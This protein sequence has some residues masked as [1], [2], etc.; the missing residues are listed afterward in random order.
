MWDDFN[1]LKWTDFLAES[2]LFAFN[3]L[4][5]VYSVERNTDNWLH[6]SFV[7]KDAS[8][9]TLPYRT[10]SFLV[11][12][13]LQQILFLFYQP[14]VELE[15]WKRFHVFKKV[16]NISRFDW[17]RQ[18]RMRDYHLSL[19]ALGKVK[20]NGPRA[21]QICIGVIIGRS[22]KTQSL[23]D[24]LIGRELNEITP[25]ANGRLDILWQTLGHGLA[26]IFWSLV[27]E[28]K[29]GFPLLSSGVF[30]EFETRQQKKNWRKL[31]SPA[32][33]VRVQNQKLA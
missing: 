6:H 32:G 15:L 26:A 4:R 25:T 12:R 10:L 16:K 20:T 30:K 23:C 27:A 33:K 31:E 19:H 14:S 29:F 22:I 13:C 5:I 9:G 8:F 17:D 28:A 18:S 21:S 11:Y 24:V 2:H 3:T 7:A 1:G